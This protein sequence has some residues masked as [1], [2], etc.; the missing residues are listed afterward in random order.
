MRHA[1][2][3]VKEAVSRPLGAMIDL[4][5]NYIQFNLASYLFL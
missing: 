5:P 4:Q 2:D 1:P 3:N